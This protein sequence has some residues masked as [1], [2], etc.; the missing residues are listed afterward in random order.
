MKKVMNGGPERRPISHIATWLMMA[1]AKRTCLANAPNFC[2]DAHASNRN[3][4]SSSPYSGVVVYTEKCWSFRISWDAA[5]L[6]LTLQE[7]TLYLHRRQPV[8]PHVVLLPIACTHTTAIRLSPPGDARN[9]KSGASPD[10]QAEAFNLIGIHVAECRKALLPTK[11]ACLVAPSE[12]ETDEG[13]RLFLVVGENPFLG[14][15]GVA[16][17]GYTDSSG[18]LR[19]IRQRRSTQSDSTSHPSRT[20]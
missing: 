1:H 8:D 2:F 5:V 4:A 10:H 12:V 13:K 7:L 11:N 14:V 19:T 9:N 16:R 20:W 6:P 15:P 18:V 3:V 17:R